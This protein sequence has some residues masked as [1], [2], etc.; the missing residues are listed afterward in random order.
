MKSRPTVFAGLLYLALAAVAFGPAADAAPQQATPRVVEAGGATLTLKQLS[1][2]S[3]A[4]QASLQALK[5]E[6]VRKNRAAVEVKLAV[7]FAPEK[8]LTEAERLKQR[9]DIAAAAAALRTAIPQAWSFAPSVDKPY[10]V[11]E[12]DQTG[13]ARLETVPGVTEIA[14]AGQLNWMRDFVE[15]RSLRAP[16]A[17][18]PAQSGL[19][20]VTPQ[21]IGGGPARPG[22]RPFHVTLIDNSPDSVRN[23]ALYCGGTLV[24]ERYV[25]TSAHCSDFV[26]P[27]QVQVMFGDTLVDNP[28]PTLNVRR[29]IQHP[30]WDSYSFDY[31]VAV[32]ELATPA[33]GIP[34]ASLASSPPAA[35]SQLLFSG[36][37]V[38]DYDPYSTSYPWYLKALYMPF[39][40][41]I[42]GA[43]SSGSSSVLGIT[44]RMICA[45]GRRG[46]SICTGDLGGPLTAP[47]ESY[48]YSELA[49]IASWT[50]GYCDTLGLPNVF[51]NVADPEISQFIRDIVFPANRKIGFVKT[52]VEVSEAGNP[53]PASKDW[54]SQLGYAVSRNKLRIEIARASGEGE[55]SVSYSTEPLSAQPRPTA[56]GGS[57]FGNRPPA[58]DYD[59]VPV[60]GVITFQPGQTVAVVTVEILDDSKLES[61]EGFKLT[62][63]SASAGWWTGDTATATVTIADND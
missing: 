21:I 3:P 16:G 8:L 63:S 34:V 37:G 33:T 5:A 15:L 13:L 23:Y 56:P 42:D 22:S 52:A 47:G 9:R 54:R 59:Y 20:S 50:A 24:A 48:S 35:G 44:P 27:D 2:Q 32:W 4:R 36:F 10:V 45:G 19:T 60:S 31:D 11:L 58:G 29:I 26:T 18:R 43:C 55:A 28:A 17:E 49:G 14:P 38:Y 12:L 53:P 51:T 25:V 39:V 62:L 40:P 7:P 41:T 46:R 1:S 61:Y 30:R 57:G 6:V